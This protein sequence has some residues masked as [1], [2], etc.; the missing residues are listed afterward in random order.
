[1]RHGNLNALAK[2]GNDSL[3]IPYFSK[4][5]KLIWLPECPISAPAIFKKLPKLLM[6]KAISDLSSHTPMMQQYGLE[7]SQCRALRGLQSSTV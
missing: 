1:M 6:N 2:L 5:S 3:L 7:Q 4:G